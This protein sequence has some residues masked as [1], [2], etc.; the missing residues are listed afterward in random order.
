MRRLVRCG[1]NGRG[2]DRRWCALVFFGGV[3]VPSEQP[4]INVPRQV[5][6]E[7]QRK[8][9][10]ADAQYVCTWILQAAV[11]GSYEFPENIIELANRVVG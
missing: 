11:I 4:K 3:I 1:K 2:E 10:E 5:N 7:E 6:R 8:L 9:K